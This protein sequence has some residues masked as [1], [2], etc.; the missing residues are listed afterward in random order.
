MREAITDYL[1]DVNET[2]RFHAVG[3]TLF[4]DDPAS[5]DKLVEIFCDEESVRIRARICDGF[6]SRKWIVPLPTHTDFKK[7][8]PSDFTLDAEGMIRR[9]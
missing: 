3:A 4:Q 2:A 7:S 1:Y 8:I 6:I 9:K 5:I